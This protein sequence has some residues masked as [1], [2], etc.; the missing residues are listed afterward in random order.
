[1]SLDSYSQARLSLLASHRAKINNVHLRPFAPPRVSVADLRALSDVSRSGLRGHLQL[2]TDLSSANTD[3]SLQLLQIISS[4][5]KVAMSID[6]CLMARHLLWVRLT[7]K[8]PRFW[9][10][11]SHACCSSWT[12]RLCLLS[13]PWTASCPLLSFPG[14]RSCSSVRPPCN[15]SSPC[16]NS[17][18]VA[19]APPGCEPPRAGPAG[20]GIEAPCS[21]RVSVWSHDALERPSC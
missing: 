20:A 12:R 9:A 16:R 6:S 13:P 2:L 21:R 11:F 3:V 5:L 19:L 1:M 4:S 7:A 10:I 18:P 14:R 15:T 17:L 8:T